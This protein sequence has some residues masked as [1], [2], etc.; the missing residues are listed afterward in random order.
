MFDK[1]KKNYVITISGGAGKNLMF[2][3]VAKNLKKV[4]DDHNIVVITP[5]PE[6]L[7]NN[8]HIDRVFRTGSTPYMHEDYL[9]GEGHLASAVEPYQDGGYLLEKEHLIKTWSRLL[10]G[11]DEFEMPSLELNRRE[12]SLFSNKIR[13]QIQTDKPLFVINPFGGPPQQEFKYNWCRD[14]PY[15]QAQEIVNYLNMEGKYTVVQIAREDQIKLENCSYFHGPLRDICCLLA[16]SQ[17]RIL[18]DSFCQ[19]ACAAMGLESIVCWVTNKPKV[20]G[21]DLHTNVL[22]KPFETHIHRVDSVY[23]QDDWSGQWNH[24]YPYETDEVFDI[25]DILNCV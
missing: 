4:F 8:K 12:L 25:A 22:A 23:Q 20:F 19:H 15:K 3:A 24:Y 6:L 9:T 5:F 2:S 14:I 16:M 21:Y 13:T 7:I 18:I 10:G 11:A 17:K 1:D